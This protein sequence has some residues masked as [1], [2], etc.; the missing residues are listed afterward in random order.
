MNNIKVNSDGTISYNDQLQSTEIAM[1]ES[2]VLRRCKLCDVIK[3]P[4]SHHCSSCQRCVTKMDHHCPWVNNCVGSYN[5]K[6]FMQ[7]LVYTFIGSTYGFLRLAWR[8]YG[9]I[10]ESGIEDCKLL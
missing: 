10:S 7:F 9:C 6:F 2:Y 5:H 1:F 3:L 8:T 4:K